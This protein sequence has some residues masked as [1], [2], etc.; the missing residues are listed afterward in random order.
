M[1]ENAITREL[2]PKTLQPSSPEISCRFAREVCGT[3]LNAEPSLEFRYQA[4]WERFKSRRGVVVGIAPDG[5]LATGSGARVG[6]AVVDALIAG[7]VLVLLE[8]KTS[9]RC[10][11]DQLAR[12]ASHWA[13]EINED[14][15][16]WKADQPPAGICLATWDHLGGW[17]ARELHRKHPKRER[18][19]LQSLADILSSSALIRLDPEIKPVPAAVA[20]AIERPPKPTPTAEIARGWDLGKVRRVCQEL[21]GIPG[22]GEHVSKYACAADAA[23]VLSDFERAD[24]QPSKRL[25][26]QQTGGPMTNRRVLSVLYG[27]EGLTDAAPRNWTVFRDR[28]IER[29]GDRAMLLTMLAWARGNP[30]D[31]RAHDVERMVSLLWE[32]TPERTPA[33]PEL[34]EA[35]TTARSS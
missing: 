8:F 9:G 22:E 23:R 29:G 1:D 10:N 24:A 31:R 32:R 15:A 19:R 20:V 13:L 3:E 2:V 34:H 27:G 35:L 4:T 12:H 26:D 6:A 33:L 21:Y 7:N 25:R 11:R 28:V 18:E 30:Q 5:T 14:A 17:L 16:A